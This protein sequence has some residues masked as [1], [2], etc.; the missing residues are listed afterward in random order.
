VAIK[1]FKKSHIVDK[2]LRRK[3]LIEEIR[4]HWSLLDCVNVTKLMEIYEDQNSVFLV[5]EYQS[6]GTLLKYIIDNKRM[7]ESLTRTTME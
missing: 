7:T 6:G 4:I 3:T 1:R 5:L 2:E